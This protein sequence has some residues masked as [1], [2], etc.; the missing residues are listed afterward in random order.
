MTSSLT[1]RAAVGLFLLAVAVV[2][3]IGNSYQ[4]RLATVALVYGIGAIGLNLL[5]GYG[6]MISSV[7]Q[8]FSASAPTRPQ[9][10]VSRD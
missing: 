8:H 5:V 10:W 7:M 9:F 4:T 2:P 1:S 6:G 3:L